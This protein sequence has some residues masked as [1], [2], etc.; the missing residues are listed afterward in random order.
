MIG[1]KKATKEDSKLVSEIGR[2]SFLESHNHSASAADIDSYIS[3]TYTSEAV[4]EELRNPENIFHLIYYNPKTCWLF[5]NQS[6][7]PC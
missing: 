2:Q 7:L 5:Q 4:R 6:E 1:I 3:K